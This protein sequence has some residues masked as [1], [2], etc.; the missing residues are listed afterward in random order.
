M[1]AINPHRLSVAPMMDWSDRHCRYFLRQI[2]RNC[3]LYTEM[4]TTGAILRGRDPQRFLDFSDE[5]LPL[6]L[7]LG[8][9]DPADLAR[10]ARIAEEWGYTEINLNVGCPSDRVQSGRFGACLMRVPEQVAEMVAA[11]RAATRLPVT[12]KHRV[13]VDELDSYEDMARFVE[14]VSAA[15]CNTFIVHARKAW[16]QG[17]SPAENRTV[18]PLRHTEVYQLKADFPQLNIELN[19]GVTSIDEVEAHLAHVDGVMLGRAA[20]HDPWILA[21]ADARVFDRPAA[22][23]LTRRRVIEAMQPYAEKVLQIPHGSLHAVT[24]HMLGLFHGQPGTRAWKRLLSTRVH[25]V[26]AGPAL[27]EE[28]MLALPREVLEQPALSLPK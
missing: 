20:Y 23:P 28:A 4:V 11:M 2:C 22:A 10:C 18:P 8:G 16:L 6:A 13:G 1:S 5:E 9:D 26:G 15:G 12:V 7:Q 21:G 17:L 14:R 25:Q 24:R 19:G 27:L 3:L